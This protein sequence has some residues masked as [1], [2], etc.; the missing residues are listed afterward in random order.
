M[1]GGLIL[2]P[3]IYILTYPP[4]SLRCEDCEIH[5]NYWI[6]RKVPKI[7][8][9]DPVLMLIKSI[10]LFIFY[11]RLV[12]HTNNL[13]NSTSKSDCYHIFWDILI[14][15]LRVPAPPWQ[16]ILPYDRN[17]SKRPF[18]LGHSIAKPYIDWKVITFL[19]KRIRSHIKIAVQGA[20]GAL[21]TSS[22]GILRD[23]FYGQFNSS[24]FPTQT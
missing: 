9:S 19:F 13:F 1:G 5:S 4:K 14:V 6:N 18:I 7:C 20:A 22:D 15:Q 23:S 3:H 17:W 11:W 16:A 8:Y 10:C 12:S 2:T 24:L 21:K